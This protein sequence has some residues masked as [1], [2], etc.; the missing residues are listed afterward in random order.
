MK[1][2]TQTTFGKPDGNCFEACL[3]SVLELSLKDVPHFTNDDWFYQYNR[4]LQWNFS[5][6]LSI[7]APSILLTLNPNTYTIAN[8]FNQ[9][10]AFHSVVMQGEVLVHDPNPDNGGLTQIESVLMFVA[11]NPARM[12]KR[13]SKKKSPV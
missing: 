13:A 7:V 11:V 3:A 6:Q 2:V 9:R 8:G 4:W 10:K 12:R 5:L 1:R